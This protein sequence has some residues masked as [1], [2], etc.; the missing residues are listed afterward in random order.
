M[1]DHWLKTDI[2]FKKINHKIVI[3]D[4]EISTG[5]V[6]YRK[7]TL[8][9]NE[10]VYTRLQKI[11]PTLAM[12]YT[13]KYLFFFTAFR[14]CPL[15]HLAHVRYTMSEIIMFFTNPYKTPML[16][17][18]LCIMTNFKQLINPKFKILSTTF[19][20]I[21]QNIFIIYNSYLVCFI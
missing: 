17:E 3:F 20:Y 1:I 13:W 19:H 21:M 4:T 6:V 15:R 18:Q 14:Y 7:N 16:Y 12:W 9:R 5:H 2:S 8:Y 10:Y 11:M